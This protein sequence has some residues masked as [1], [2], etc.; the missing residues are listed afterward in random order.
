MTALV[1]LLTSQISNAQDVKEPATH[2][3]SAETEDEPLSFWASI[4]DTFAIIFVAEIADKVGLNSKQTFIMVIIFSMS[5]NKWMVYA[6]ATITMVL[7]HTIATFLGRLAAN[8][9]WSL[10]AGV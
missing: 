6:G 1:L 2:D 5:M 8:F 9:R 7:M 10:S 3:P 4:A